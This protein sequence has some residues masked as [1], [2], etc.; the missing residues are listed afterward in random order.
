MKICYNDYQI[1][2]IFSSTLE[3]SQY[4]LLVMKARIS[5][6]RLT[7]CGSK[8]EIPFISMLLLSLFVAAQCSNGM[9]VRRQDI[10]FTFLP[11]GFHPMYVHSILLCSTTILIYVEVEGLLH[12]SITTKFTM[13]YLEKLNI[14]RRIRPLRSWEKMPIHFCILTANKA[15]RIQKLCQNCI[16]SH[17]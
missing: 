7:S 4:P 10:C 16:G 6:M 3:L 11:R 2:L 17:E 13:P 15:R 5:R 8:K 14:M 9:K 12:P 1:I